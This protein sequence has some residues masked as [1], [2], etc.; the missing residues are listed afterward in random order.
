MLCS[1]HLSNNTSDQSRSDAPPEPREEEGK[2][3][4]EAVMVA[5]GE[6]AGARFQQ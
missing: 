4:D 3:A 2:A 6:G 1:S 5:A